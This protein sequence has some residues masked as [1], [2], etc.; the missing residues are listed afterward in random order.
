MSD[1]QDS[2]ERKGVRKKEQRD[3][4]LSASNNPQRFTEVGS[5]ADSEKGTSVVGGERDQEVL[6]VGESSEVSRVYV[7]CHDLRPV[8]GPFETD[9]RWHVDS[10]TP[11]LNSS[12]LYY[13]SLGFNPRRGLG[14]R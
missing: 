3:V 13:P 2:D 10:Q 11:D 4:S 12:F 6:E 7:S 1:R 14:T 5:L 9:S 8:S